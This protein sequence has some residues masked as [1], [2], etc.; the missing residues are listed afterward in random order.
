MCLVE[1]VEIGS[2]ADVKVPVK[3]ILYEVF[4]VYTV[5]AAASERSAQIKCPVFDPCFP[6]GD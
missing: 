5:A 4:A 6:K 2:S 1:G 3:L